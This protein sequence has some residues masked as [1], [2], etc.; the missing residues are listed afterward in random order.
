MKNKFTRINCAFTAL[1]VFRILIFAFV[2]LI[3]NQYPALGQRIT[4]SDTP[5]QSRTMRLQFSGEEPRALSMVAGDFDEDGVGDLV[6][7]YGLQKGGTISFLRGNL[8]ARAP[9]TYESW[10][11]AGRHV[12]SAPYLQS[13]KPLSVTVQ[14]NLM[15]SADLNGDGHLDLVYATKGSNQLNVMFGDGKGN[16]SKPVSTAVGGSVTAL[17][18]YRPGAPLLGEAIVAAYQLNQGARLSILSYQ[19]NVWATNATYGLPSAATAMSVANLD[20]DRIPD[21][22]IVA[23]GQLLILHGKNAFSGHGS[24]T[25]VPVSGAES[26]A[27]GEFLFD[28]HAQLQ[29]SVMT[30]S[31]DVVT[32]A[33]EGFDPQPYT[34][35]E[36]AEMRLAQRGHANNAQALAQQASNTGDAPW[37]EVERNSAAAVHPAGSGAPIIMRS[38]STGGFDDL[39]IL[40]S[41]QQQRMLISHSS[42][43]PRGLSSSA[44]MPSA[45]IVSNSLPSGGVVAA[46]SAR[47]SPDA[48]EGLVILNA[49]SVSPQITLPS[50]GNTFYVST[51]ADN[52]GT[53]TDPSDGTRCTQ[54]FRRDLH[55]ARCCYI[56]QQRWTGQYRRGHV[57]HDH[58]SRG[59][60]Q[61]DLAS[62]DPGCQRECPYTPRD[63]WTDDHHWQHIRRRGHYRC[64]E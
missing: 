28:R 25:T 62:R 13:S 14:P 50:T 18:A 31:G 7:G 54:G 45:R 58:D 64:N 39:A 59:H 60:L 35:Q 6:I 26:V 8:D 57:R 23:G 40:N 61:S 12:Y 47:V 63:S 9:Q 49:D 53:T 29:L 37:I 55:L 43:S 36:I 46:V 42:M 15:I 27:T 22:A 24:I 21:T 33:H 44:L 41:S 5:Q 32:L 52:T 16:F 20:A 11:S 51:T 30:S 4:V 17:A 19:G 56:R 34:P 3:L 2:W 10:A 38:R 48:R 1:D